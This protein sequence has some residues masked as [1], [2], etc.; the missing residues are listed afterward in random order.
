MCA[1]VSMCMYVYVC[2]YACGVHAPYR[3]PEIDQSHTAG[4]S[5]H[6][7][8]SSGIKLMLTLPKEA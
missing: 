6:T 5:I 1:R 8:Q 7:H 3:C 4:V 2:V